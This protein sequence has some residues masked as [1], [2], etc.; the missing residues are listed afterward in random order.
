MEDAVRKRF[1]LE[2]TESNHVSFDKVSYSF[3][4]SM[5]LYYSVLI[6]GFYPTQQIY[7]TLYIM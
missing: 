2:L 7:S 3:F 6:C 5:L 1:I 4:P